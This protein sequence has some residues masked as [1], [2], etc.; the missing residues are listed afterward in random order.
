MLQFLLQRWRSVCCAVHGIR[1]LLQT[2][3]NAR[4][5]LIATV[6]VVALGAYLH[7]AR[8][9]WALLVLAMA[10]VWLAEALN[11]GI[12]FAVDLACPDHHPLAGKAKDVAAAAVLLASLSAVLVGFLVFAPYLMA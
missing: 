4:V 12:E 3:I 11:T 6:C 9:D 7:I 8:T 1:V 2:Q 10:T 5:H